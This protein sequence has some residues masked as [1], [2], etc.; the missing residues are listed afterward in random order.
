MHF[1]IH[2]AIIICLA[3]HSTCVYCNTEPWI[4][5]P[6]FVYNM[7]CIQ[8]PDLYTHVCE[9]AAFYVNFASWTVNSVLVL[10]ELFKCNFKKSYVLWFQIDSEYSSYEQLSKFLNVNINYKHCLPTYYQLFILYDLSCCQQMIN[11]LLSFYALY[12][13]F[14]NLFNLHNYAS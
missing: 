13:L 12:M 10:N 14:T 4:L 11:T 6:C 9:M 7:K 2:F 3:M 5:D 8:I 1:V